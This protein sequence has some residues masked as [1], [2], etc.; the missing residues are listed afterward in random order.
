MEFPEARIIVFCKAPV[1]G[2]VKTRLAQTIGDAQAAQLHQSLAHHCLK[3]LAGAG[4]APVQLWCAPDA[5][6]PFFQECRDIYGVELREQTG[7]DL[8][9]KMSRA[10]ERSLSDARQCVVVGTDCPAIDAAVVREALTALSDGADGVIGPAEDGGYYL[11]GMTRP[12]P[13]LFN[14]VSWGTH[15]VL[16]QTKA[17]MTGRWREL[18]TLWDVDRPE[19]LQRLNTQRNIF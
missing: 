15:D 10:F 12:M 2:K 7:A 17:K 4:V 14:G 18:A 8:G 9:E 3:N 1:P 19:D 13:E 11:L 5:D 16:A 6:H